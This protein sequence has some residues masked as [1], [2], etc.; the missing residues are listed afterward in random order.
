[1]SA[2]YGASEAWIGSNLNPRNSPEDTL[3]TLASDVAYLEFIPLLLSEDNGA[4]TA[5]KALRSD[6][7]YAEPVEGEP[8]GI[9]NLHIGQEYEPVLTT[10]T[11]QCNQQSQPAQTSLSDPPF[12]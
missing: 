7:N 12:R 1:M 2:H 8:V 9:D 10:R 11:G 5:D 4:A 6:L 3:F